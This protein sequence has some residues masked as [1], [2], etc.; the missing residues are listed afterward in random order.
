MIKSSF[1]LGSI[2]PNLTFITVVGPALL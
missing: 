2:L 1:L